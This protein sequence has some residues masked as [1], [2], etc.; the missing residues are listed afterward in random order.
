MRSYAQPALS[1][2]IAK[3]GALFQI[4]ICNS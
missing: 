2:V 1:T 3:F 4:I